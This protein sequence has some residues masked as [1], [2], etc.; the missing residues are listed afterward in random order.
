MGK[1][2]LRRFEENK[3]FSCLYQPEFEEVF[4]TDYH[5]KGLWHKEVFKNDNPI[6]LELGCGRGEYT[7]DLAKE[8]PEKNFIGIDIKGARLWRGAKSVVEEKIP[9]AAF[10]RCRIE[11]IDS[12]FAA[13][14]VSEVWITFADPQIRRDNKRLTGVQFLEKYMTFM[15]NNGLVH[16]K[17]DSPYLYEFTCALVKQSGYEILEENKDIYG[18]GRADK[19]LSIK[20]HYEKQYLER[21]IPITYL[22]FKL[23]QDIRPVFPEWDPELYPR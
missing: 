14:E 1:D 2:K 23:N 11:F 9:N 4:R 20:T 22:S 6:V 10:V 15:K 18:S 19:I 12:L 7:V 13:G 21:G 16:L 8:F 17:T 3:S 5:L